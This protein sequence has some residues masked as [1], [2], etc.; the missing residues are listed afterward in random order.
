MS[1][2]DRRTGDAADV[3]HSAEY[4]ANPGPPTSLFRGRGPDRFFRRIGWLADAIEPIGARLPPGHAPPP[5]TGDLPVRVARVDRPAPDVA[6]LTLV[7]ATPGAR[8]PAWQPGHHVD[9][10]LGGGVVRQYSLNGDPRD[11]SSYRIAVRR[12][13]GGAGSELVHALTEGDPVGLRG[14]RN[15]FPFAR[16]ERY[17]FVAGGIGVTPILPMVREAHRAGT[18][19]RMVY[20]GRSR[21]SMPFVDE[22]PEGADV[23]VRPDDECGVP[24]AA[25][26]LAGLGPGT[27][28]Y[29]CGPAP[30]IG[31]VRARVPAGTPFFSERFA[32]APIADGAPFEVRLGRDGPV[33]SVRAD[34]TALEAVRRVRPQTP[35]SCRQGFCGTCRVRLLAGSPDHRDRPTGGSP[36]GEE[37]ALCVSRAPEGER[38]VVDL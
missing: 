16:A 15:A 11:R 2:G 23:V 6:A 1:G 9:V 24:D 3:K 28:V 4:Y 32:P 18:P 29:V 13:P 27:A 12:I 25:E 17:L 21:E 30:L 19:F 31:A 34:E 37:F 38:L 35:Y 8:L 36:R 22:L 7:P 5:P 14:P 26:I 33:L 10:V 20:T